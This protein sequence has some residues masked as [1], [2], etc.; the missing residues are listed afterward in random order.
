MFLNF[1]QYIVYQSASGCKSE[2]VHSDLQLELLLF[3]FDTILAT[4]VYRAGKK[5][6]N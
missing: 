4:V 3:Q 1:V 5:I 2:P 6:G